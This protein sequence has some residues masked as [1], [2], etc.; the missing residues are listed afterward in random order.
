MLEVQATQK[1]AALHALHSG[2]DQSESI[3]AHVTTAVEEREKEG[4]R[5]AESSQLCKADGAKLLLFVCLTERGM[6][7]D[8]AMANSDVTA[9]QLRRHCQRVFQRQTGDASKQP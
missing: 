1:D 9:S 3:A 4:E 8:R 7:A 6:Q 5:A 2:V